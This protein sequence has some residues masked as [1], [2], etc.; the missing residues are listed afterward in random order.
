M[1]TFFLILFI[2]VCIFLI[3][4]ILLQSSKASGMGLF[5]SGTQNIFGAQTGDVLTKATTILATIFFLGTIVLAIFQ[6]RKT[7]IVEKQIRE[8]QKTAPPPEQQDQTQIPVGTNLGE[9][10][11]TNK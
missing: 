7:S 10:K 9:I 8:L 3:L 2:I 6:A 5:G 1:Y 4:I 11:I